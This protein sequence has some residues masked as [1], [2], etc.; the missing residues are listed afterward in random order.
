[1]MDTRRTL[2]IQATSHIY[3]QRA[4]YRCCMMRNLS[5]RR[6]GGGSGAKIVVL[7]R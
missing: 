2:E 5:E 3:S 1:M 7:Q 4:K 6:T